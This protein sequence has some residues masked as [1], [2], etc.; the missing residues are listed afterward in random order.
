MTVTLE[1]GVSQSLK[2]PQANCSPLSVD[3]IN[4]KVREAQYAVR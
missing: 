4:P 2:G 3:N 1:N